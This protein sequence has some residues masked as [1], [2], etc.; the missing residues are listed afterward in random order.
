VPDPLAPFTEADTTEDPLE[1]YARWYAEA[2]A[3]L[4]E[5]EAVVLATATPGGR[6][7]L[8]LVLLKEFGPRGFVF[9]TNYEGR[10]GRE[11][12]ANPLRR[13]SPTGSL[14]AARSGSRD[15]PSG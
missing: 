15:G 11:L 2:S 13:C 9:Y 14:S 6:P 7:S 10:K 4:E 1:L 8:R 5:P 12:A 3:V